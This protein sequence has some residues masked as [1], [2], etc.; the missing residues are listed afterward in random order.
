MHRVAPAMHPAGI[1][2]SAGFAQRGKEQNNRCDFAGKSLRDTQWNKSKS[3]IFTCRH[4]ARG[5][6]RI[7]GPE[8]AEIAGHSLNRNQRLIDLRRALPVLRSGCEITQS[9]GRKRAIFARENVKGKRNDN[10]EPRLV[11]PE[12]CYGEITLLSLRIDVHKNNARIGKINTC[13]V[14]YKMYVRGKI[15]V[16]T[17]ANF[18]EIGFRFSLIFPQNSIHILMRNPSFTGCR[19]E[20][21]L[22]GKITLYLFLCPCTVLRRREHLQKYVFRQHANDLASLGSDCTC[23]TTRIKPRYVLH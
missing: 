7:F 12:S 18:V 9:G 2:R 1:T 21:K 17:S 3:R 22:T 13:Y 20:W 19:L 8:F 14:D 5:P 6:S 10:D 23:A 11:V 4:F 16:A 15:Y